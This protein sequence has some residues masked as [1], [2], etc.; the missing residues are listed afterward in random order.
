MVKISEAAK[1]Y[2]SSTTQNIADLNSVS[3]DLE[4]IS[5][6][7]ELIDKQTGQPKIVKQEVVLVDDIKYRVPVSVK[8]QLKILL[9]DNPN[10]KKFK[11]KRIGT[12]KDDTRYQ[13][14]PV[15]E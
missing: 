15:M 14:I 8:Q 10:L 13:C 2:K 11:V 7:F 6:E 9:E 3:T 5:D 12:T 4:L 1:E